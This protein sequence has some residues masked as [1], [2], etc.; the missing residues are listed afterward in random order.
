M[1][2]LSLG[3][4]PAVCSA[5]AKLRLLRPAVIAVVAASSFFARPLA[6]HAVRCASSL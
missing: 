5:G 4:T 1:S 2:G 3:R 6:G